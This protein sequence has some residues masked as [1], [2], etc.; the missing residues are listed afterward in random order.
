MD[1]IKVTD[2][3]PEEGQRVIVTRV[4]M[5]NMSGSKMVD[6][7]DCGDWIEYQ[8]GRFMRF[9]YEWDEWSDITDSVTHWMPYPEPA[10][11]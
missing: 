3:L 6:C 7:G 2:R 9:S 8:N 4:P 1:W 10:E 11:D 5:L